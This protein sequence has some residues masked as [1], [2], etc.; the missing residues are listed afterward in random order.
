MCGIQTTLSLS[1]SYSAA[2]RDRQSKYSLEE[3]ITRRLKN[4]EDGE[5][6]SHRKK[7]FERRQSDLVTLGAADLCIFELRESITRKALGKL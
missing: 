5:I 4:R 6:G 2:S 7:E 1:Y 3:E